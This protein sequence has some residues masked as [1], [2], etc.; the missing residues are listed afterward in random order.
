MCIGCL[1]DN[2]VGYTGAG[3]LKNKMPAWV[4][5]CGVLLFI[6]IPGACATAVNGSYG[7]AGFYDQLCNAVTIGAFPGGFQA[8]TFSLTIL[9]HCVK[10]DLMREAAFGIADQPSF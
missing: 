5:M 10:L 9:V 2:N 4:P 7:L 3:R 8:G 1:A 6:N